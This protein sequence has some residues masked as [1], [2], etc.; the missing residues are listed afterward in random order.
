M[1]INI[2][3]PHKEKFDL[4]KASAVSITVKNNLFYSRYLNDVI[5]FGQ[6]VE[7][8]IF[9]NNF[10]GIKNSFFSFKGKNKFLTQEMLKIIL[11][12][13]DKKQLIEVHNRPYLIN[14][15]TKKTKLF[16]I[17]LFFHNDPKT[18]KGS[19]SIE[20]RENIMQERRTPTQ[21]GWTE[22]LGNRMPD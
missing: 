20:E 10:I 22:V 13:D 6:D 8:P 17:S 4:N 14:E 9:K 1:K 19:K 12:C 15:I 21:L 7:T 3:L 16:P 18:M 2:L 5:V 11:G